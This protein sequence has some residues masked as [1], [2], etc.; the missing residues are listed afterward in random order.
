MICSLK[1]WILMDEK[2]LPQKEAVSFLYL[3][4]LSDYHIFYPLQNLP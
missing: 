2:K 3:N 4:N 1:Y